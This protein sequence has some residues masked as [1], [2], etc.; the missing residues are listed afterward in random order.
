VPRRK[1]VSSNTVIA[2]DIGYIEF[3]GG[4]LE[5]LS[6]NNKVIGSVVTILFRSKIM[7][8]FN[9]SSSLYF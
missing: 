8:V 2:D 9:G 5:R 7:P 3:S 6:A 1:L 4:T